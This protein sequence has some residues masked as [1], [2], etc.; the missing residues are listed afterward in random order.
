MGRGVAR[1]VALVAVLFAVVAVALAGA[2]GYL[3]WDR[4]QTRAEKQTRDTLPQ[5]AIEQIPVIFGYDYQTVERSLD[6]AELLLTA[7]YKAEFEDTAA[8][9]IIPEARE[10]QLVTQANVV[11]AGMLDAGR[12]SGS[13][14]VF[15][16]RTVTDK[17]KQPVYDGS[18]VR[19]D[20]VK[21]LGQWKIDKITP[22]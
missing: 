21:V 17:S 12:N 18:R 20:Y 5:L 19:V 22:I 1:L 9:R 15:L 8:K 16:N 13:V 7:D 10:R 14:L 4:V 3:Y 11:G 6:A 2:G